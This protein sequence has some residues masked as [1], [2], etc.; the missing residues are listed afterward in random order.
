MNLLS[1]YKQHL[2]GAL[3]A[4]ALVLATLIAV[5]GHGQ[6]KAGQLSHAQAQAA[7]NVLFQAADTE[8]VITDA[9]GQKRPATV[10]EILQVV[11]KERV[12]QFKQQQA[13]AAARETAAAPSQPKPG[14]GGR[15]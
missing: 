9:N 3:V 11:A 5:W 6:Y 14:G 7:V 10:G 1:S 15:P 2:A 13:Q 4:I 12:A 8:F